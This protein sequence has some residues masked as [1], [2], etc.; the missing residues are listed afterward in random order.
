MA[1]I[2]GLILAGGRS[3]RMGGG[4]KTALSLGGPPMIQCIADRLQRQV[5]MVAVSSN[6]EAGTLA[7]LGLAVL[8]D[9]IPGFQGPLA[10]ILAGLEWGLSIQAERLITVAGD[11]PF[12]P[13]NL[14][15]KLTA[16]APA[17]HMVVAASQRG[18]HPT[19]AVW[20]TSLSSDLRRYLEAGETRKVTAF[21]ERHPHTT[22][23]FDN[24]DLPGGAVDPFFNIN[25]PDDLAE[26]RRLLHDGG[27]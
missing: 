19:F 8:A 6:S 15:E 18:L 12:F 23:M 25:T 7:Q 16:A 1:G 24:V 5:G 17:S 26:A 4:D 2:V 9:S 14:V 10:G 27:Q 11:T 13:T 20:P 22:T 21:I 3:S